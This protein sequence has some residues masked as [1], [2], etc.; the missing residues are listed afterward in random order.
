MHLYP[1][2]ETQQGTVA[3]SAT[4]HVPTGP[5]DRE[6]QTVLAAILMRESQPLNLAHC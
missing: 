4:L 5:D 1:E 6:K 2:G 3:T